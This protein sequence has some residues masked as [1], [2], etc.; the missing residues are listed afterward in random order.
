MQYGILFINRKEVGSKKVES[1]KLKVRSV[2]LTIPCPRGRWNVKT[3]AK[4]TS[5]KF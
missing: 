4:E 1:G 5:R 3:T 2:N